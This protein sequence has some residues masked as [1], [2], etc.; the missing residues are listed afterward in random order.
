MQLVGKWHLQPLSWQQNMLCTINIT[1]PLLFSRHFGAGTQ[2]QIVTMEKHLCFLVMAE[3][4]QPSQQLRGQ[5][6]KFWPQATRPIWQV[7]TEVE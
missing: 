1:S 4:A 2:E 7:K 5:L 3:R 6:F